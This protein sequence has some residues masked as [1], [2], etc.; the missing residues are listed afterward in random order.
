M[1]I[2]KNCGFETLKKSLYNEHKELGC[3]K[4]SFY[5][6]ENIKLKIPIDIFNILCASMIYYYAESEAR[7]ARGEYEDQLIKDN[8]AICKKTYEFMKLLDNSKMLKIF[9]AEFPIIFGQCVAK[10]Y[11]LNLTYETNNKESVEI[12]FEPP[13]KTKKS[14]SDNICKKLKKYGWNLVEE[15]GELLWSFIIFGNKKG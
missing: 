10:N 15:G 5:N 14:L 9:N 11:K 1:Y 3:D 6:Q 4:S 12:W 7:E 8:Q 2:C 13:N